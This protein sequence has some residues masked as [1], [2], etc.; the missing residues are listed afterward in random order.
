M[1]GRFTRTVTC[2]LWTCLTVAAL[3]LSSCR[4]SE[5]PRE[6]TSVPGIV[7]VLDP[8]QCLTCGLNIDRW[9]QL[10]IKEPEIVK[11]VV[12]RLPTA[13]ERVMLMQLRLDLDTASLP[14][15]V[16]PR[17]GSAV[18]IAASGSGKVKVIPALGVQPDSL[19]EEWRRS[20]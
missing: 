13:D 4:G 8:S 5:P 6:S 15:V 16:L 17:A 1:A 3:Q 12:R 7:L 9:R 14:R 19:L 11:V 18:V 10:S 20:P 2:L